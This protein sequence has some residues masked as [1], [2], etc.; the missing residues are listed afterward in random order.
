M[1]VAVNSECT[2]FVGCQHR[3]TIVEEVSAVDTSA[4]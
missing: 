1:H 3:G 2:K 4:D